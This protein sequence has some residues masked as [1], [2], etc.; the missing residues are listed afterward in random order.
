MF[1]EHLVEVVWLETSNFTKDQGKTQNP[2]F[3]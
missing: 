2:S 3:I 1:L